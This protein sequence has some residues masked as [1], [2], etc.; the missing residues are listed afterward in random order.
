MC[1]I[2]GVVCKSHYG[3]SQKQV[4]MF[5]QL[6]RADELR[7]EDSTGLIYVTNGASFGIMKEASPAGW[8]ASTM[9][10][11]NLLNDK[12]RKGKALIGHNRK[13]TVG[14][15]TDDTAH[16]FVV[17]NKFAM[18][19]NGTLRQH[20][21]IKQT[22]V[23]SEALAHVFADILKK[24]VSQEKLE[25]EVGKVDGAFATASYQ[26][27]ENR[28]YLLRN[29][30][31]PLYFLELSD[32]FVWGSEAGMVLW[33]A[34]RNG[35]DL[36]KVNGYVLKEHT[37]LSI[38]LANNGIE[39]RE[40]TPKKTLPP[41]TKVTGVVHSTTS[42]GN[43]SNKGGL[44]KQECKRI[45]RR[46][47][48]QKH[49]FYVDEWVET[50]FPQKQLDNGAEE[51]YLMGECDSDVFTNIPH[52]VSAKVNITS[53]F[54]DKVPEDF[55]DVM[56]SG[57]ITDITYNQFT[58]KVMFQMEQVVSFPQADVKT[59]MAKVLGTTNT[60]WTAL[61]PPE[62]PLIPTKAPD[63]M[64]E[65]EWKAAARSYRYDYTTKKW[66]LRETS[67]TLH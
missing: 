57:V 34:G 20:H 14:R 46:F 42:V 65:S 23:D 12:I 31:R 2:V 58:K 33:I 1:G 10:R 54:P 18:V 24:D 35:Y 28:V 43:A 26:Q 61:P 29:T 56:Y 17:D 53:L 9:L 11:D 49:L 60:K 47:L 40:F 16:P 4:D 41:V 5:E 22:E 19:H 27:E 67:T 44:S 30:E 13:A 51:V 39:H 32:C 66:I 25:E 21:K 36:T 7:G 50:T 6:L 37:C 62:T 8:C 55:C 38:D 63:D 59:T 45:K 3:F 64:N 48:G 52:V 15:I